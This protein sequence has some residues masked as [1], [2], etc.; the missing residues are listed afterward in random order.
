VTKKVVG[1]AAFFVRRQVRLGDEA[2]QVPESHPLPRHGIAPYQRRRF[3]KTVDRTGHE[4][5]VT[6]MDRSQNS[7]D[8]DGL[9][10][11][12]DKGRLEACWNDG[13]GLEW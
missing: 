6:A 10:L 4:Q 11:A 12:Y 2:R 3:H 9:P 13:T 5:R 8:E 1:G 7:L